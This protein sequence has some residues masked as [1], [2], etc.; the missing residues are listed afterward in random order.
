MGY[1]SLSSL[2]LVIS[3]GA[4]SLQVAYSQVVY[5]KPNATAPCPMSD[6]SSCH[7]LSWYGRERLSSNGTVVK[8][9]KGMHI[10]NSTIHIENRKNLT[11]TG[12]DGYTLS[13]TDDRGKIPH[14]VTWIN[15]T[16]SAETG[17]IVLNSTDIKFMN[18]G[19]DSC[20][21][22]AAFNSGAGEFNVS[23]ALFFGTSYNVSISQVIINN[24][25]GSGLHMN[26]VFGN[27]WIN[28]SILV[29][30]SKERDGR[31]GGNA[32][33]QWFGQSSGCKNQCSTKLQ[34]WKF[35][36]HGSCK[37]LTVDLE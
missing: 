28:D 5:V 20:G 23:A 18:L 6:D 10:L 8:L 33:L 9:L 7:T 4:V 2:E 14:P 35:F 1:S 16:S 27:I 21:T 17:I 29:R 3:I 22:N 30:T 13:F 31:L 11:I 26:C 34:I 24:T 36:D 15:C 32:K 19:F 25:Y 12:E 37:V